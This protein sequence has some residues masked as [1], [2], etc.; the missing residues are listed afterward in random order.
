[1]SV[2]R[3]ASGGAHYNYFRD[4]DP[5]T[6]RYAESD[7]IGIWGGVNTYSYVL[8]NPISRFDRDGRIAFVIPF[9]PAIGEAILYLGSAAATAAAIVSCQD[10]ED[11]KRCKAV[12]RGCKKGCLDAWHGGELEGSGNLIDRLRKCVRACMEAS[13]CHNF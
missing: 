4:Y 13:G 12:L 7:P 5:A 2:R 1:V 8:G 11:E 9:L 3:R 10:S 6:G